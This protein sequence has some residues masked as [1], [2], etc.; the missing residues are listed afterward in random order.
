LF[1]PRSIRFQTS[2]LNVRKDEPDRQLWLNPFNDVLELRAFALAPDIPVSLR[3]ARALRAFYDA[4]AATQN[5]EVVEL[6]VRD[7]RG[8]PSIWLVLTQ[9]VKPRGTQYVGS[10]TLPFA[11]GS[12][13]MKMQAIEVLTVRESDDPTLDATFPDH[14]LSRVRRALRD[15]EATVLLD[16]MLEREAPFNPRKPSWMFWR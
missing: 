4:G 1:T 16:P 12:F 14:A 7:V 6:E 9:P 5:A 3:D 2:G 8:V 10:L 15:F 11:Q 13:V